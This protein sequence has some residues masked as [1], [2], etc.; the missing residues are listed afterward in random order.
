MPSYTASL[1]LIQPATGEYSGTWG[2]QVNTGITALVDSSIAGT[3]S[4]TMTAANYTLT[5]ANGASDESRAMFLVLG[6]T[7]GAAREVIVPAVSKLYFV[8]NNT[9]G[10]FAQT[11]KTASG[12]G[13]SVPNGASMTLRCDG[14]NVV[15]AQN[16][17][18]SLTLGSAL[19]V[20]SGGTGA[21][22][23]TGSG[24]VVLATSPTLTTPVLGAASAT[25]VANGLGA[26][27][28]PSYT[29]TGDTNTGMWSP[30]ADT[31]AW[32]NNGAETM[33]LDASGN[34][35]IGVASPAYRVDVSGP[36]VPFRINSSNNNNVLAISTFGTI[37]GYLGSS[38]TNLLFGT[39]GG[40][41]AMRLNSSG[42][43]GV[44]TSSPSQKLHVN[45]AGSTYIR[46][47]STNAGTG[48]GLFTAN[49][50]N[51]YIIGAGAASGGS[52]LEFR[53]DTNSVTRMV[54]TSGGDFGIGTTS[55]SARLHV[56]GNAVYT[57]PVSFAGATG[58][59][60]W[61]TGFGSQAVNASI[62]AT[63]S[64]IGANIYSVSDE[65]LKSNITPIPENAGLEFVKAVDPVSFDWKADNSHD[66]G[67]IAQAL[68]AKGYG[69]LVS[70]VPDG[71][72][73]EV[74]HED[75]N[76][77]P[78]GARFVVRYD[79]IVPVLHA[80]IRDQQ[81]LIEALMA[82]VAALEAA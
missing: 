45:G 22:T 50:T 56:S 61:T 9:T 8:T 69:H 16:Y 62:L 17:F 14:T 2:T 53:D 49:A 48:S 26:V 24:A 40:S 1:R 32:S 19:P 4:I 13:I 70:A 66:T 65:R 63:D 6:G 37:G 12:S 15:I 68:M 78:A 81:A 20:A 25:S 73:K 21:T 75:G 38:G 39:S 30:A 77:S 71:A 28:T 36:S 59:A 43:L 7:P 82:R 33:R 52:G 47:S 31:L 35:G 11:V 74:T 54:L 18:A 3:T 27:T 55:V 51:S 57:I 64:V 23:S 42:N 5:T 46:V 76:V 44:G 72:M 80:A 29:F 67:F 34:L 41:E 10:G 58:N 79:S 60:S